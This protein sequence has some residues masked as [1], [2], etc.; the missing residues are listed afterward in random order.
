MFSSRSFIV[1][2]LTFR[3][4]IHFEFIFVYGVRK[5]SSFILLQASLKEEAAAA[6]RW[7]ALRDA[8]SAAL[9]GVADGLSLHRGPVSPAGRLP[10]GSR[11]TFITSQKMPLRGQTSSLTRSL[12]PGKIIQKLGGA[13]CSGTRSSSDLQQHLLHEDSGRCGRHIG[14]DVPREEG[15]DPRVNGSGLT[16]TTPTPP[17]PGALLPTPGSTLPL[18]QPCLLVRIAAESGPFP[19]SQRLPLNVCS[20]SSW[21]ST[22]QDWREVSADGTRKS[23]LQSAVS[24]QPS[25]GCTS[26]P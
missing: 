5:C 24:P 8:P 15:A 16:H 17:P 3:S 4:L 20:D 14:A 18:A 23:T 9:G 22:G 19:L 2:G 12:I 21:C 6:L 13:S 26:A 11:L 25:D 7:E 1:S 10:A